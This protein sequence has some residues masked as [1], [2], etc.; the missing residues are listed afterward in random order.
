M[1]I[2]DFVRLSRAHVW[3]LLFLT[4][5]GAG[6]AYVIT[7]RM[8]EVYLADASGYVVVGSDAQT[9]G[10]GLAATTLGGTKADSYLPLVTGR[11]VAQRAIEATGIHGDAGPGGGPG[12]GLGGTRVGHPQGDGDRAEPGGGAAA[13]RRGHRGDR[14]GGRPDREDRQL[15]AGHDPPGAD[16][17]DRGR[18]ARRQDRPGP[19]AQ[20]AHRCGRRPP[21]RLRAGLPAAPARHPPAHRGRRRGADRG[22][23]ARGRA[24]HPR[25]ARPRQPRPGPARPGG[26][27]VPA[28][29]HQPALRQ[30]RPGAAQHRRSPARTPAR[31]SRRC[32]PPWPGCSARR[33]SPP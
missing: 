26:R 5:V 1:T 19:A 17:A 10:E 16:R 2:L 4:L 15:V 22:Q 28:D 11:A 29:P 3:S 32:R 18:P 13:R 20:R 25:A 7:Q 24:A 27:G 8:P 33:A 23:R 31:A 21:R 30:R 6:S 14:G 12:V 9:T